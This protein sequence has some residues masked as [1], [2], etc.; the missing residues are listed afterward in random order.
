MDIIID[1]QKS[2]GSYVEDKKTGKRYLDMLNQYSS[3]PLGYNHPYLCS[4]EFYNEVELN[5]GHKLAMGLYGSESKESFLKEFK[6]FA[7][8]PGFNFLH[9]S[10]TGSLAVEAAI[11]TAWAHSNYKKKKILV[12]Q[13]DFHGLNS[14]GNF[15]T[16]RFDERLFRVPTA[17]WAEK[18]EFIYS[19]GKEELYEEVAAV[20]IEPIQSTAGDK[21]VGLDYIKQARK[22]CTAYDI[23]LIFDEIQTGF[24][25]SGKVWYHE[26]LGVTPD[27]LIF[28]KKAQVSGIMVADNVNKIKNT[29]GKLSVTFD[30]DL[31]DMIRSKYVIKAIKELNLLENITKRS[32]DLIEQLSHQNQLLKLRSCAGIIAFDLIATPWRDLF[33]KKAFEN[34]LIVNTAGEHTIRLRPNLAITSEEVRDCSIKIDQT[35]K[36]MSQNAN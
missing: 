12:L 15:L 20:I 9:F 14:F 27:I 29:I 1:T 35:L 16:T 30:G 23:P 2:S 10:C 33:V 13:N 4:D 7:V 21:Y 32:V 19:Y 28:G 6:Q 11:K 26:H 17:D 36:S 31:L 3:L 25:A 34:G 18:F 5:C 22:L 24:G 8:P